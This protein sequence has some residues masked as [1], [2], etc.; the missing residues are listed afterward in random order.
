MA[1]API[2]KP[3]APTTSPIL[4]ASGRPMV[5]TA[6]TAFEAGQDIA[7]RQIQQAAASRIVPPPNPVT[8]VATNAGMPNI[9]LTAEDIA[10]RAAS[11]A[12][13]SAA[14]AAADAS[15]NI[16]SR[17][18]PYLTKGLG[19]L[20]SLPVQAGLMAMYP[21]DLGPKVPSQGPFRGFELNPKTN[22]PWTAN[23]IAEAEKMPMPTKR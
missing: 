21:S 18:A 7:R 11:T 8:T 10:E 15:A 19:F 23:E 5:R 2:P 6:P 20:G 17:M 4:D 14:P 1:E 22:R 16:V 3:V 13:K 9:A 12:A